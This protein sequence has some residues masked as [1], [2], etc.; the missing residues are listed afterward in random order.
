MA[1]LVGL[2]SFGNQI[3]NNVTAS[4]VTGDTQDT[5]PT[6]STGTS[7]GN[8]NHLGIDGY[9]NNKWDFL[10]VS[11]TLDGG[12]NFWHSSNNH[13]PLLVASVD[14]TGLSIP[15]QIILN[16]TVNNLTNSINP[17]AI[18]LNDN[19]G[20]YSNIQCDSMGFSVNDGTIYKTS[21]FSSQ[22]LQMK[23]WLTNNKISMNDNTITLNDNTDVNTNIIDKSQVALTNNTNKNS[24]IISS[25]SVLVRNTNTS[26]HVSINNNSLNISNDTNTY[27]S[28][29]TQTKFYLANTSPSYLQTIQIQQYP[30]IS[31]TATDGTNTSV[32][33]PS[34]L[35][36]NSVSLQTT[37][38]NIQIK[39]I[40]SFNQYISSTIYADGR[41]PTTPPSSISQTYAFTP[42]WYFKNTTAGYKINWYIGPDISMTVS[43]V[44]GVY[45]NIFNAS[46][47]STDSSPFIIIYTQPQSGDSTFYHS[48]RTYLFNQSITPT[49]N[50]RYL[51][52]KNVSNTCP[53]PN[54]YGSTLINMQLST[55]SGNNVGPFASTELILAF[56]IG[57][58]S[59]SPVNAVEFAVNKF[60]IMT[61]TG[62]TEINFIPST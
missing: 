46:T 11:G 34:D 45:M 4:N 31:I 44:L 36:F 35:T 51:M 55:V 52:F 20:T 3:N 15:T 54:H 13:A 1:L 2:N 8:Y 9:N 49:V 59:A 7:T 6:T 18:E 50:T 33:T 30:N 19:N 16:D 21:I 58:N 39:Q 10:N 27:S 25:D 23:N 17:Q 24:V 47:T 43:Q 57:S 42:C 32:L 28:G 56:S 26:S 5:F 22:M 40:T 38:N 12:F 14:D 29:I 53:N 61:P 37:L 62:T 60:G 41:P 48:K